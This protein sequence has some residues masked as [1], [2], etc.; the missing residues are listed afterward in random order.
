[1]SF[2]EDWISTNL[3]EYNIL[4]KLYYRVHGKQAVFSVDG[5][6]MP[7]EKETDLQVLISAEN[8]EHEIDLY[9]SHSF[10]G[11]I[12]TVNMLGSIGNGCVI[13]VHGMHIF[14]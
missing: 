11:P 2:I 6:L 5:D 4:E 10:F 1:M 13:C 7:I 9:I 3:N 8:N 14:Q 12:F